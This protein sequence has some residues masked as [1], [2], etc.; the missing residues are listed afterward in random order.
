VTLLLEG[1]FEEQWEGARATVKAET[2]FRRVHRL[3]DSFFVFQILFSRDAT[4][5]GT[6]YKICTKSTG[7]WF[8]TRHNE[9][10]SLTRK[11]LNKER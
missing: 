2:D 5:T 11:R 3:M 4:A 8:T 9:D 1:V 10:N 7:W 6:V